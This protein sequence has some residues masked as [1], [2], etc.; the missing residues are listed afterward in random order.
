[1]QRPLVLRFTV[2]CHILRPRRLLRQAN[3]YTAFFLCNLQDAMWLLCTITSH[4][5][6]I[7]QDRVPQVQDHP[8]PA[9]LLRPPLPLSPLLPLLL[10]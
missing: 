4:T 9:L 7:L 10:P 5:I 2:R 8:H 1:M 6:N 3:S